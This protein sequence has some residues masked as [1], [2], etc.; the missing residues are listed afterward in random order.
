MKAPN[1]DTSYLETF[2]EIVVGFY[3]NPH[4]E[5]LIEIKNNQMWAFAMQLT[6][7]FEEINKD[8]FWDGEF[9]DEIDEFLNEKL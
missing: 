6:D 2:Y 4:S 1:G 7:E 5:V 3:S 9:Y 8:R